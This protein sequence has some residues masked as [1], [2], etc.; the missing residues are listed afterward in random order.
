MSNILQND[1]II[2]P[3]ESEFLHNIHGQPILLEY[4]QPE[5]KRII[6]TD[7]IVDHVHLHYRQDLT[8][9]S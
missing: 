1:F 2:Q 8:L 6:K 9:F 7:A 4:M 5:Y 3:L